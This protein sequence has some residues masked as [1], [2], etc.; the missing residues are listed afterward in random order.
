VVTEWGAGNGGNTA[1]VY[2]DTSLC[3]KNIILY[4]VFF[5]QE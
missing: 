5:L 3:F 2:K 4:T 1:H